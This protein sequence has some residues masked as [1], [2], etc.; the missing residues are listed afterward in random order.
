MKNLEAQVG[1]VREKAKLFE[2]E[3]KAQIRNDQTKVAL[4]MEQMRQQMAAES[5]NIQWRAQQL[6]LAETQKVAAAESAA[7]VN[8]NEGQSELNAARLEAEL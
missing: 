6:V 1:H 4:Q 7:Q 3:T 8:K 2:E 5:L